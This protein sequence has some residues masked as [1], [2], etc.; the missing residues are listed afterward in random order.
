MSRGGGDD[1]R[2]DD[3]RLRDWRA[4]LAER[5]GV[6]K[7]IASGLAYLHDEC[8]A[9]CRDVKPDNIGFYRRHRRACGCGAGSSA[10]RIGG[11]G[12]CSCY[13]EVPKLFDFGLC[14]EL[15]STHLWAHPDHGADVACDTYKLT[16]R[17]GTRRYM[18]P[19]VALSLPYNDRVDVYSLGV[20]LYQVSSLVA[21]F[22][23]YSFDRHERE[24]LRGGG[25][26]SLE[27]PS[28]RRI[29]SLLAKGEESNSH[30]RWLLEN[31]LRKKYNRLELRT[32]CVWTGELQR[33][34][35]DCWQGDMRLRPTMRDVVARL[36]DCI[37][38]LTRIKRD[39]SDGLEGN[40]M[41]MTGRSLSL[42]I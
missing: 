15:K 37:Q 13:D 9:V 29:A 10:G 41:R 25:R 6:I 26:P 20:T 21:P 32:K 2:D 34:I 31:D 24:V 39:M 30:E 17:C 19:E 18:A 40:K 8:R 33:L 12:I 1:L 16:G 3:S 14:K 38:E 22:W 4:D 27:I 23:A 36:E 11:G 42:S 7:S 35:R 5:L 28:S